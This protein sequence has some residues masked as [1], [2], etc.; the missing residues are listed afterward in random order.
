VYDT[1]ALSLMRA[2]YTQADWRSDPERALARVQQSFDARVA[3]AEDDPAQPQS[4][5]AFSVLRRPPV[6]A[7]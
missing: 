1:A 2:F 6:V 3:G 7:P 4:W 5:A